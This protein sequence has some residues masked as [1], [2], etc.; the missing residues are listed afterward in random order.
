MKTSNLENVSC[1][2]HFAHAI[3]MSRLFNSHTIS[4][5]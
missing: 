3:H 4:F 1:T 2:P 5:P